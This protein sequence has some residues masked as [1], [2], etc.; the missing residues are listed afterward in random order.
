[1]VTEEKTKQLY[2]V[3]SQTGT[4][5]SRILKFITHKQYNHASLSLASDLSTMYSFGRLHP[6]NPFFGGFVT[7]SP[8]HG[9]FKRFK[10]TD[11]I[12]L[13]LPISEEQYGTVVNMLRS[14]KEQH[15]KYH[16][17]YLGLCL[18]YFH[19]HMRYK[20]RFYCSEFV[21]EV[22]ERNNVDG[23]DTLGAIVH[24]MNFLNIPA[25]ETVYIGK[26]KNYQNK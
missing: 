3:V 23:Y 21:K 24:P 25:A 15:K 13:A 19:I 16:Y 6:Y 26:L 5:L 11:V 2:I 12:V 14:M 18:A 17:N 20:N 1:M 7:E 8:N 4:L 9:T 22:L 10:N